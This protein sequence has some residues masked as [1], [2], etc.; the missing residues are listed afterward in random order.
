M[1]CVKEQSRAGAAGVMTVLAALLVCLLFH[2]AVS[3]CFSYHH[4]KLNRDR[5]VTA[6]VGM[7]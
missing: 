5:S 6:C 1:S 4:I 7:S 2:T 3:F